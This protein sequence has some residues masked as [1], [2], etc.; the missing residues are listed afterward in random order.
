MALRRVVMGLVLAVALPA[1]LAFAQ[2]QSFDSWLQGFSAKAQAQGIPQPVIDN[3]FKGL[4]VDDYVIKLDRKQPEGTIT[5]TK[6]VSNAV[7]PRRVRQGREYM[8]NHRALLNQISQT[9]GVE[10][11]IIIALW[12]IET[13]YGANTGNFSVIQSLATLAY[14]GRRAELFEKQLMAALQIIAS[15][16]WNQFDLIGSWAGAMGNCQFMPTSYQKYAVDWDKDGKADIW[17]SLPDTFASIANYLK[18]EGWQ[19]NTGWG[20]R[21][22]TMYPGKPE[23]GGF[24]TTSNYDVLLHW[25]RSRYFATSVGLLSDELRK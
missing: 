11:Q 6:Y 24:T 19:P 17:H 1:S 20:K 4:T 22:G 18:T 21:G 5:F 12:G 14:E 15:G 2:Q 13:D 3:A 7:N 16:Q 25:N 10:P 8:Q 9:Y 23:E